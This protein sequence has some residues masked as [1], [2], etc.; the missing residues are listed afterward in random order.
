MT[1]VSSPLGG[2][3][4]T[5]HYLI[6]IAFLENVLCILQFVEFYEIILLFTF[7]LEIILASYFVVPNCNHIQTV[8]ISNLRI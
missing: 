6:N 4:V 5:Y 3:K 2:K 1:L 7:L 8:S